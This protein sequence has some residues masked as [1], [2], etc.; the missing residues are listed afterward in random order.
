MMRTLIIAF[1]VLQGCGV[2]IWWGIVL[3]SPQA[4]ALFVAPGAPDSTLLAFLGADLLLYAGGSL[5]SAYGLA[6]GR[7]WAWT[8]LCIHTGAAVYAALYGL[9][10]PLFSGGAWL[11]ALLMCPSLIVLPFVLWH[12]GQERKHA[13]S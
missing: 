1:L 12:V 3:V 7:G 6:G 8:A 2:L 9:A 11:G 4:R 5:V 13:S 10:L